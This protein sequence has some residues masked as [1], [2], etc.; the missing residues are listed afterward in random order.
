MEKKKKKGK[1]WRTKEIRREIGW[2]IRQQTRQT[3]T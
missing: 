1:K 3:N 2:T